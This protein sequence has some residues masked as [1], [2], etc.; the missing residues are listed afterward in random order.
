MLIAP[1]RAG[2][3]EPGYS[4]CCSRRR[5][6]GVSC[7]KTALI[8]APVRASKRHGNR[9]VRSGGRALP[10]TCGARAA[11]VPA[12]DVAFAHGLAERTAV[13]PRVSPLPA[14][15][16]PLARVPAAARSQRS[17]W[18]SPVP[19]G[20]RRGAGRAR[21]VEAPAIRHRALDAHSRR[22]RPG[23]RTGGCIPAA[24]LTGRQ[25]D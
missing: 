20:P 19:H 22:S 1:A 6:G 17:G 11:A 8:P 3:A 13:I 9:P 16:V 5:G 24:T 12:A 23:L 14:G 15:R 18:P 4:V 7:Q 2:R 21:I 25:P 10:R